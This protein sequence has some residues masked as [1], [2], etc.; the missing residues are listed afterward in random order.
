[1]I[2]FDALDVVIAVFII[3]SAMVFIYVIIVALDK[4]EEN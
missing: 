2:A 1:M 4:L 3:V